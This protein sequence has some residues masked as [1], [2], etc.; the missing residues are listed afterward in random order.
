MNAPDPRPSRHAPDDSTHQLRQ[1]FHDRWKRVG[2]PP[3]EDLPDLP[4][5]FE[6]RCHTRFLVTRFSIEGLREFT[7]EDPAEAGAEAEQEGTTWIHVT[8]VHHAGKIRALGNAFN[9]EPLTIEDIMNLWSRPRLDLND[10]EVFLTTRAVRLEPEE[11]VLHSQQ[12]SL[13]VHGNTVLSFAEDDEEIFPR[14]RQRLRS[15]RSRIRRSG[16]GFLAYCLLDT[17]VD[18]LLAT[19]EAIEESIVD[20]EENMLETDELPVGDLYRR[21]RL[22]LG[23]NRMAFPLRD[24]VHDLHDVSDEVLGESLRPYLRD[25]LDHA[26]R[27]AERAEH[28]RV[29]LHDLQD[30]HHSRQDARLNRSMQTLTVIGTIFVPLTFVAGVYGMNFEPTAGP[31]NMPLI[32]DPYGYPIALGGMVV[33]AIAMT[34]YF[35]RKGWL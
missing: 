15:G 4:S 31:W 32:T 3:G 27:A 25:L 26:R 14:V 34:V 30:Y 33:F 20:M 22:A 11:E 18:G 19:S 17:L 35:K 12:V 1:E 29:R 16:A 8:G 2:L 28:A 5:D 13:V 7:T 23:L 9:L 24:A 21:K 10:K 6:R